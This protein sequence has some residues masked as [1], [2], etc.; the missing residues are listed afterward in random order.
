VNFIG[1]KFNRLSMTSDPIV[2]NGFAVFFVAATQNI[3]EVLI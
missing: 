3:T 1:Y 2:N